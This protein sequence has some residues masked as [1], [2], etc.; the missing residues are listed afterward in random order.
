VN[1]RALGEAMVR[2]GWVL[3]ASLYLGGKYFAAE[4]EA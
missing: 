4:T 1:G 2:S 3:D